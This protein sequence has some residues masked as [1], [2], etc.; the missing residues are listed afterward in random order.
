MLRINFHFKSRKASS[1]TP[2]LGCP[3]SLGTNI[4]NHD[5]E[6]PA[7]SRSTSGLLR[8]PPEILLMIS[9]LL[10]RY[11]D[12]N[13]LILTHP[14]LASILSSVLYRRALSPSGYG[15][16]LL[17]RASVIAGAH[18]RLQLLL[19][20]YGLDPNDTLAVGWREQTPLHIAVSNSDINS[21]RILLE[22]G[23]N[24]NATDSTTTT[25]LHLASRSGNVEMITLLASHGADL[26]AVDNDNLTPLHRALVS[27]S[28]NRVAA[29]SALLG[30]G[31]NPN[32]LVRVSRLPGAQI[33]WS[34]L[35]LAAVDCLDSQNM[36]RLLVEHGADLEQPLLN[37]D[38]PCTPL[39]FVAEFLVWFRLGHS[40][41]VRRSLKLVGREYNE[42]WKAVELL[43][44][45]GADIEPALR[46]MDQQQNSA[47]M[48]GVNIIKNPHSVVTY[49]RMLPSRTLLNKRFPCMIT[50]GRW[51]AE[52]E[53]VKKGLWRARARVRS[54]EILMNCAGRNVNRVAPASK[55]WFRLS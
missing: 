12:L 51:E 14:R 11:G 30:L 24:V 16:P 6:G 48:G 10:T 43:L 18:S 2:D 45:E 36:I 29:V 34:P 46:A 47:Q 50:E 13:S 15:G 38:P 33:G 25:A 31:A 8:L 40:D 37:T 7:K 49:L 39:A 1:K 4:A 26:E 27:G 35:H 53:Y 22:A 44:E 28:R 5:Q 23:I 32:A 42:H 17:L 21:A 55:S 52:G 3:Q 9:A 54:R 19:T 41:T 20:S